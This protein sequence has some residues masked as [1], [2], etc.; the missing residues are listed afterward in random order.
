M[1]NQ[2]CRQPKSNHSTVRNT[3]VMNFRELKS[4]LL[5]EEEIS[6]HITGCSCFTRC[7]KFMHF[8]AKLQ[9]KDRDV[10][11]LDFT[12]CPTSHEVP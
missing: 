7:V 6:S 12:Y 1:S 9:L 3:S 8:T 4:H 11:L 10:I 5:E 2:V